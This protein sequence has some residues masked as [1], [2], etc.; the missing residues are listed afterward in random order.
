M[1]GFGAG[2]ETNR[3][4]ADYFVVAGLSSEPTLMQDST[5]LEEVLPITDIAVIITSQKEVAPLEYQMIERTPTGFPADLNHGSLRC[6]SV[7]LCF[8]RGLDKPPLM[9]IGVLY[10]DKHRIM[11]DSEV[12]KTT[13]YGRVANVN[14]SSSTKTFLTYRRAPETLACNSLVVKD[15]VVI[16]ANKGEM[17][18]HAFCKID[19]NLNK[20]VIGSDVYLCYKKSIHRPPLILYQPETLFRFPAADKRQFPLPQQVHLFGLP[21]GATVE[22]WRLNAD[23]PSPEFSTFVFTSQSA[24]KAYGASLSFYEPYEPTPE[25]AAA[26]GGVSTKER[27]YATKSICLIS[28]WPFFRPFRKFLQFLYTQS[29]C[30]KRENSIEQYVLHFLYNIPF[31]SIERPRVIVPLSDDMTLA[32][33]HLTD[34]A[35]PMSGASFLELLLNLGPDNCLVTLLLVLTE[36]KILIHSLRPHV[37]TC[38]AEALV[39]ACFPLSWQCPYVPLCPLGVAGVIMAP[40]AFLVGVDSRYFDMHVLPNDVVCVDLDTN[41][42]FIP[43]DKQQFGQRMMPKRATRKLRSTL[44]D[45]YELVRHSTMQRR[46]TLASIKDRTEADFVVL[47]KE[48]DLELLIQEAFLKFMVEILRDF[49]HYLRSVTEQPKN[50]SAETLF[51]VDNFLRSRDKN[52]LQFYEMIVHTQMFSRLVEE[53]SFLSEND[54]SLAFFDQCCDMCDCNGE[55]TDVLLHIGAGEDNHTAYIAPPERPQNPDLLRFRGWERLDFGAFGNMF[56]DDKVPDDTNGLTTTADEQ[57]GSPVIKRTK[58]EVKSAMKAARQQNDVPARWGRALLSA[59]YAVWFVHLPSYLATMSLEE[60]PA[61]VRV[62]FQIL[63]DAQQR[64]RCPVDE[65]CYRVIL[66]QCAVLSQPALAVKVLMEMKRRTLIPNAMTYG[67]YN[68]AVMASAWPQ[69]RAW[70]RLRNVVHGVAQF[71]TALRRSRSTSVAASSNSL[72]GITNITRISSTL[73]LPRSCKETYIPSA[74]LLMSS[75]QTPASRQA[76]PTRSA[77]NPLPRAKSSINITM[78]KEIKEDTAFIKFKTLPASMALLD[79]PREFFAKT[80]SPSLQRMGNYGSGLLQSFQLSNKIRRFSAGPVR[81]SDFNDLRRPNSSP[82]ARQTLGGSSP[83]T[84]ASSGL[85]VIRSMASRL[86]SMINTEAYRMST[87]RSLDQ[88]FNKVP[89]AEVSGGERDGSSQDLSKMVA[90]EVA[91]PGGSVHVWISSCCQCVNCKSLVYDEEIMSGWTADDS[92]LK[93]KCWCNAT[94]VPQLYVTV[95]DRRGLRCPEEYVLPCSDFTV[96]YLSPL[97]LQKEVENVLAG[98]NEVF[99][100]PNFVDEHPIIYWNL[101]WYFSR[102]RLPTHIQQLCL[103]SGLLRKGLQCMSPEVTNRPEGL[104]TEGCD[105]PAEV[106]VRTVWDNPKL[107]ECITPP[108]YTIYKPGDLYIDEND[109]MGFKRAG[110]T[111]LDHMKSGSESNV[112]DAVIFLMRERR[113]WNFKRNPSIYREL[114]FLLILE[115]GA[116]IINAGWLTS[117]STILVAI[118]DTVKG[119]LHVGIG[120]TGN[121]IGSMTTFRLHI[122]RRFSSMIGTPASMRSSPEDTSATW[123]FSE[124]VHFEE[125]KQSENCFDDGPRQVC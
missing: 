50:V 58:H 30:G 114:L 40:M 118:A 35:L 45:L 1:D 115:F 124:D 67:Y 81:Q 56:V 11:H 12:L 42:I 60:R 123:T 25:E 4:L 17:P 73:S 33:R 19:Y 10:E 106:V 32:L 9:D 8:R 101:M 16:L 69:S 72:E 7:Y 24:T 38:V 23:K 93:T 122:G 105:E 61:A 41:A 37:V 39:S 89:P 68:K 15:I 96:P 34:T 57:P 20:S 54:H 104:T 84:T 59:C 28:R 98:G 109:P 121:I 36:N 3:R 26:L 74:G 47:R 80:V 90:G 76:T 92:N 62:A 78:E 43:D 49:R 103:G 77:V 91:R 63:C 75:S 102:L 70:R 83:A 22:K 14:N 87:S 100:R 95:R 97:V 66:S 82:T 117:L 44:N 55:L 53:R 27:C 112:R 51:D 125:T 107:H 86:T 94:F 5:E 99:T 29:V 21:L 65:V 52:H 111:V 31:P 13:P 85:D 2:A 120:W 64:L 110:R 119:E 79:Q 6:P 18:P 48:R 71:R 88:M 116:N 113:R 108:L 46:D